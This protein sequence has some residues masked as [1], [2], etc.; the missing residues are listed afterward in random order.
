VVRAALPD[1]AA[2]R[3]PRLHTALADLHSIYTSL[4]DQGETSHAT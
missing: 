2:D 1:A 3:L 4:L